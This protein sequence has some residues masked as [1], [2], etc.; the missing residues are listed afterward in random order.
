MGYEVIERTVDKYGQLFLVPDIEVNTFWTNTGLPDDTVIELYHKHGECEQFHSEIKTDMDVERLPSGKFDTNR[1]VVELT[2]LAY[3]I[4]RIMGQVSLIGGDSPQT[5]H[6][7]T[8]RRLRTVINNLILIAGHITSHSR[9]LI[10]A[11]GRCNLWRF[12]FVYL[13][14]R[15]AAV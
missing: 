2:I 10:L 3:N 15:F 6:P 4:L 1:L 5:R 9:K 8:R 7:V 12:A 11:L 14:R 13:F